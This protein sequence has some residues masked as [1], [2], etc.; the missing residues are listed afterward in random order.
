MKIAYSWLKDYIDIDLA[1]EQLGDILT[2]TGLEVGG[3]EEVETVKGGLK[4]VVIGE[5]KTCV[6]HSNSD[7]LSVTT[8]DV[9]ADELLPIVCGA[10]NVA[11]GQKV[12]VATVG[13]TLYDGD[14][15]FKIKKSKIRGEVS[16]GMICAEDEIGLGT[17]HDGIMVLDAD[18]P[19]GTAAA[20]YFNISSDYVIEIDLTPNRIDGASLIG[21][22]RDLAAYLKQK[23]AID[24]KKPSVNAFKVDNTNAPIDVEIGTPEAC[25]RY[26]GVTISG[27]T[28]QESPEWLKNRLRLIG[29]APINNVVDITNYVLF[30]TAQPLHAF[31]M[32]EVAGN[33]IVV[34]T[35]AEGTEFVTLDEEERKL[36]AK[37]LMICNETEPMCIGGVFGGAKSGVK[38]TTTSIFL[39]SA[40][41][42]PVYIRKTARRHGLSTDASFRFER[43]TD[44]NGVIYALKRAALLIKEIAGGEISSEIVD[45]YPT[46]AQH[47]DVE[48]S[49]KNIK[50]LIGVEIP[51]AQIKNILG[52]LEIDVVAEDSEKLTLKVPPYRVDVQ[53]E[54]DVIEEILRIYGYNTVE[55][56][57]HVNSTIQY[58]SKPNP[59][60]VIN[61]ISDYLTSNGFNEIWSNSLTKAGYYENLETY[62]ADNT[63]AILNPLSQD[64]NAMRQSMLFGGLES[65]SRNTK[66]QNADLKLYEFG[67]TYFY[68][69]IEVKNSPAEKYNEE[70]HLG[71]F[72]SGNRS[73]ENWNE[74]IQ[75]TSFYTLK[76]YVEGILKMLGFNI[77]KLKVEGLQNDIFDDALDYQRGDGKSIVKFGYVNTNLVKNADLESAVFYAD[78]D[79]DFVMAAI[80]NNKVAYTELPKF[81][82]VRRDL[83]LLVDESV[84]FGQLKQIAF[85]AEKKLLR[86]VDIFDVY[87]GKNL[88]A[89]KKS[90]ALSFILR[91]DQKTLKDKAI[92]ATMNRLINMYKREVNAELR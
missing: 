65:I 36:D 81:P 62:K 22:A 58:S 21:V 76:S 53:R 9:G 34:K 60:N 14:N 23:Q 44:P 88:P 86:K 73:D 61:R 67:N 35:V 89:G 2:Q 46:P 52:G 40:W 68:N 75:P 54:A 51:K 82:A 16:M 91:D 1:P 74:K 47:F 43:G 59:E 57:M 64:L 8:V 83:A 77:D 25:P 80:K 19:V 18:A 38:N 32:A 3:I 70:M 45:I 20:K 79:W 71:I 55:P 27:L 85:K 41:F 10:P 56:E 5:V 30:E 37:D 26:A 92:D 28:I 48:V 24:Y 69:N 42:D 4:G 31:D 15:E 50:R 7:H 39:E 13:T 87:R 66:F 17:S 33:K 78:F 6:P 63:V 72:I 49:F 90:Y 29:L 84:S 12:V 11:A